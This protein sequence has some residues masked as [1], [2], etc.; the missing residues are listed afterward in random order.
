MFAVMLI[1]FLVYI[2]LAVMPVCESGQR[3]LGMLSC[4]RLPALCDH[5]LQRLRHTRILQQRLAA[6][7]VHGELCNRLGEVLFRRQRH[8]SL[9]GRRHQRWRRDSLAGRWVR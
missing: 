7:W 1:V 6:W 9:P 8:V 3:S 2:T 4:L 5:S